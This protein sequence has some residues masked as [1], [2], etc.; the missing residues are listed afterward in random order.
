MKNYLELQR[1]NKWLVEEPTFAR[2]TES[3]EFVIHK[4]GTEKENLVFSFWEY[5]TVEY[6]LYVFIVKNRK[7]EKI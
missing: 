4:L 1:Y 7:E 6:F 3:K 5:I 2:G